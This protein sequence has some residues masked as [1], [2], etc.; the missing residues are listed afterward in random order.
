MYVFPVFRS[1]MYSGFIY[2]KKT[3]KIVKN[4]IACIAK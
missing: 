4:R 3:Q 1:F 2:I